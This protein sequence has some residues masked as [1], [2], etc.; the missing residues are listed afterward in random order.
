MSNDPVHNPRDPATAE[1]PT[2]ASLLEANAAYYH[3]FEALDGI[4]MAELWE[5]SER[6][7]C[8]HPGWHALRGR[9]AVMESWQGIMANT[10]AIRFTLSGVE[11]SVSGEMGVVTQHEN[12]V[13]TA[14]KEKHTAAAV[15]TNLFAHYGGAGWKLFH[16]HASLTALKDEDMG[17]LN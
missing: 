13:T 12:I 11:C 17:T 5:E 6:L 10:S 15:S 1:G 2:E 7:F 14:G 8:V 9:R 3:A 4:A 16:H